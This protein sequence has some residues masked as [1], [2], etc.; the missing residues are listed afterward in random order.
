M[1]PRLCP[2]QRCLEVWGLELLL[3][4][5][6]P[7]GKELRTPPRLYP[8]EDLLL[9]PHQRPSWGRK[10]LYLHPHLPGPRDHWPHSSQT[11][12]TVK[13]DFEECLKDSPRFRASIELVEAEVSEL[14][15]R[16]E[17][18]T[19]DQIKMREVEPGRKLDMENE[20]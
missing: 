18:V 20:S 16:L 7:L 10:C 3:G 5:P 9:L 14:E 11:E 12:M 1:G 8:G 17:K 13:L 19:R 4:H 15:T 6:F 2:S